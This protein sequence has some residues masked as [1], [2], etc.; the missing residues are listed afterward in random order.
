MRTLVSTA[1]V[2][3]SVSLGLC[4]PAVD[5]R[6][7]GVDWLS[8][9]GYMSPPNTRTGRLQTAESIQKALR[10][11]QRFAGIEETG[12]LDSATLALMET[13][14]C[15]LPDI[16]GTEDLLRKRKRRRRRRKKDVSGLTWDNTDITW[17]IHSYPSPVL[18]PSLQE[19]RLVE[20]ILTY[21]LKVWS[22]LVPLDFHFLQ[23]GVEG[24]IRVAFA[25]SYHDDG[26]PF[27]GRGG[28]LAHAFYPGA[29][30]MAG[31][32]HF[33]DEES[34]GYGYG[35]DHG[36]TDLFTVAVHEF[37]HALG[38]SHSSSDVSIMRP[39]YEGTVGDIVNY[40][41]PTDDRVAIQAV[42]DPA[43]PDRC[44]GKYDAVA[45]IRGE[46][47]FF[48][49]P[50]FW[51]V[52]G[53]PPTP[54]SPALIHNFWV[55]LPL[56][57]DGVDAVYERT[58]GHIVFFTGDLYWVFKDTVSLP[59]Y[60]RCLAEWGMHTATGQALPRVE[61]A[62][63][64]AHNRKTYLFSEGQFWRFSEAG[65][66]RRLEAG[67]PKLASIWAG[68]PSEPD[69]IISWGDGDSYFFK[70]TSYWVLKR[71]GLDQGNVTPKSVAMDWMKCETSEPSPTKLPNHRG[72]NCSFL[73]L[74]LM[75][76]V[77]WNDF[78][79]LC[80]SAPGEPAL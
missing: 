25:W 71:G 67:Y 57:V 34:W 54:S 44:E 79:A 12:E 7:H 78:Y 47:F 61:A 29:A 11:M 60:P 9:Y 2:F 27:D 20:L 48:K 59:G 22:D 39:Y 42:Y 56:L 14:R 21:A 74:M 50:F 72:E 24:D 16:T 62:F 73:A 49:G 76:E 43:L 30:R 38:L 51:R 40:M 33:D 35:D 1:V 37:G 46:V 8:R 36:T 26:Y 13:P 69:D 63:V 28:T 70:D 23:G 31:D 55:G 45:N 80:A 18:S 5:Q 52:R 65:Q 15:S 75:P 17:S 53:S 32:T 64:W 10:Q 68:V 3:W 41:L 4:A 19:T 77:V 6:S 66:E 58:D